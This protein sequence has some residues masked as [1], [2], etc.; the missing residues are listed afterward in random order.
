MAYCPKSFTMFI[1][2]VVDFSY[3]VRWLTIAIKLGVGKNTSIKQNLK[4]N[5]IVNNSNS[6]G[7]LYTN[8]F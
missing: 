6:V 1:A 3:L 2:C 7:S 8:I 5:F 4:L